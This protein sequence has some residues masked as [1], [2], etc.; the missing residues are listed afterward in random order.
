MPD[1]NRSRSFADRLRDRD[2]VLGLIVKMPNPALVEQARYLGFDLVVIDTEH[3]AGDDL[4]LEHHLRA[5]GSAGI[6]ALVRVGSNSPLDILRALDA[7]AA[8]VIVPHVADAAAAGEAVASAH[9]PPR[10][11]RGLAVSTRGGRY[12]DEP[13]DEYLARV[14]AQTVVVVQVED[15]AGVRNAA[16]VVATPGVDGVWVGPGDLSASLGFPGQGDHPRV[17]AAVEQ[18]VAEVV[19]A[20]RTAAA[21]LVKSA[22][23]IKEWHALGASMF[24]ITSI[25]LFGRAAR[26]LVAAAGALDDARHDVKEAAQ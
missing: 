1:P 11:R 12:G 18:V 23:E 22:H 24:L 25:D 20:E 4:L 5:A 15:E 10:G 6:D 17:R 16:E 2:P 21:V 3:G 19:R 9:Y 13:I 8:G 14:A 7:G 26:E